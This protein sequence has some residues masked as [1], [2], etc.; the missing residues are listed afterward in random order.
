MSMHAV[1]DKPH[2]QRIVEFYL[3]R[4]QSNGQK[5]AMDTATLL[6]WMLGAALVGGGARA[7]FGVGRN[8]M[9]SAHANDVDE[10]VDESVTVPV[11]VTPEQYE[12]YRRR[13]SQMGLDKQGSDKEAAWYD[14]IIYTLGAA[15]GLGLGWMGVS[16][17]MKKLRN[18]R[19]NAEL[20]RVRQELSSL[21]DTPSQLP[22]DPQEED[23]QKAAA[24]D[25]LE[26]MAEKVVG[27]SQKTAKFGLG[28]LGALGK[29]L[30][31]PAAWGLAAAPAASLAAGGGYAAYKG[32]TEP[33]AGKGVVSGAAGIF[34]EPFLQILGATLGPVAALVGIHSLVKGYNASRSS[35]EQQAKLK[36]FR[37]QIYGRESR[38]T[39]HVRLVPRVKAKKEEEEEQ[40]QDPNRLGLNVSYGKAAVDKAVELATAKYSQVT[41]LGL[42]GMLGGPP[43]ETQEGDGA[44]LPPVQGKGTIPPPSPEVRQQAAAT[45]AGQQLEAQKM[46]QQAGGMPPGMPPAAPGMPPVAPGMPPTPPM[47]AAGAMPA[48]AMG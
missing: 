26:D 32:L 36:Q 13:Q 33:G 16:Q 3:R 40:Q 12:E 1:S 46:E 18:A 20:K 37:R 39:P 25:W 35:S 42:G 4:G 47:P 10:L 2:R 41:G 30:R 17:V 19:L 15:G 27:G 21:T 45:P 6:K 28:R 29:K 24:Y 8:L 9:P 44:I 22:E 31:R 5:T 48:P 7:A 14:N 38:K 11:D 43:A 34:G 23:L